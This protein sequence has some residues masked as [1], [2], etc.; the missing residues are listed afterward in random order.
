RGQ[1]LVAIPRLQQPGQ[2]LPKS[3]PLRYRHEQVVELGRVL[4]QRP[5]CGRAIT[6]RGHHKPP[7]RAKRFYPRIISTTRSNKLCSQTTARSKRCAVGSSAGG[8]SPIRS[9]YRLRG[10]VGA[11]GGCDRGAAAQSSSPAVA[12]VTAALPRRPG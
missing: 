8:G 12:P 4:L 10:R 7:E 2:A 6:T 11:R 3:P 1:R 9:R 5:R